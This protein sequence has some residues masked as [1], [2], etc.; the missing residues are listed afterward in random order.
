MSDLLPALLAALI[1]SVLIDAFA[2]PQAPRLLRRPLAIWLI[3][4]TT[5]VPFGLSLAVSGDPIFASIFSL[6]LHLLTVLASNTKIR[7][8]GEPLLFSD[9]ALIGG[10][11]RH[12]QFYFSVLT[13]WQKAA[14]LIALAALPVVL[15]FLVRPNLEMAINGSMIAGAGLVLSDLGVRIGGLLRIAQRPDLER[16]AT[17]LGLV[18]TILFY[19]LRWRKSPRA[20]VDPQADGP[21]GDDPARAN[22][23]FDLVVVV[24]CE[25]YADPAELFGDV[26]EPLSW[27]QACRKDSAQWGN[28]QVSGFGAYTMRTEY[29]VLFGR[30]EA[31]LG[32]RRFDPYLTA[33]DDVPCALPNRLDSAHW[34]SLFV[35]PHDMRFYN[36]DRI[37]PAAGFDELV[38]KD[39][40]DPPE[41]QQG[42]YVTDA[43]VAEKIL[44]I[45]GKTDMPSFIYSVTIENH[46]PWAPHRGA[47]T[48]HMVEN[49]TRLVRAGDRMLGQLREG[50]AKLEKRALLVFFGDHRPSIPGVSKPGGDR[51]TP[52]VMLRF[53]RDGRV[54]T[55]R[56]SRKDLS[57][58]QL[59][60]V[61][62]A[63]NNG[64]IIGKNTS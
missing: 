16:D 29:G 44:E 39:Q 52:Y 6:A 53:D 47:G 26:G 14:G 50:I 4:S 28:L 62:L 60:E 19:W 48:D 31:D 42:R 17:S 45:A 35:H 2:L 9:F 34:R 54:E 51:H 32:F 15:C 63:M 40:F 37:L 5:L 24:Q 21:K 3:A 49:Y 7:V 13:Q 23:A 12:P 43:A 57:P 25:S 33:M 59:H 58:A 27:L 22:D 64:R 61:I 46:G 1:G 8:L 11:F 36:R 10:I 56:N 41:P 55:L 38:G 30:D 18:P 20:C